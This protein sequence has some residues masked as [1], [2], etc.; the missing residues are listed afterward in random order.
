MPED[1]DELPEL[2]QVNFTLEELEVIIN[3]TTYTDNLMLNDDPDM[4]EL[5]R[6]VTEKKLKRLGRKAFVA[7]NYRMADI[8]L[9]HIKKTSKSGFVLDRDGEIKF[10]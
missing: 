6:F 5:S 7:L 1:K 10:L 3:L 9:G 8:L 4:I 2:I